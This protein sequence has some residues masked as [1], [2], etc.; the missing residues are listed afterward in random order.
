MPPPMGTFFLIL[1]TKIVEDHIVSEIKL[2]AERHC[3]LSFQSPV[4]IPLI[5][6]GNF[7]EILVDNT[8]GVFLRRPFSILDVDYNAN[9]ISFYIK[10]IG[11]GTQKLRSLR[12]GDRVNLIYP[13]GNEFQIHENIRK[14]LIVTGGSGIA[15]FIL[16]GKALKE[17][18]VDIVFLIGGKSKSDI[19]LIEEFSCLGK[20]L[21]TTEDG[22]MGEKG[23]VTQHSLFRDSFGFDGIY[24]PGPDPMM[25]AVAGIA[26]EK[27]V[28]CQASLENMMACG[29][30]ICL[31]CVTPTR[32]GNKRVCFEGPVFDANYL[33]WEN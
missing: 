2:Q 3:I 7:A 27:G 14:A 26:R 16:L 15:P 10:S 19:L 4:K 24:T 11:K 9:K 29:L 8:D 17:K 30:G 21:I 18:K 23:L 28:V 5:Q 13:L 1:M 25:K 22:S 32:E 31:C 33:K 20:V 6:P 12:T